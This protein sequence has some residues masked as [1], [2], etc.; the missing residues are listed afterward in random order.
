MCTPTKTVGIEQTTQVGMDGLATLRSNVMHYVYRVRL[1][2]GLQYQFIKPSLREWDHCS[3]DV[4]ISYP[5]RT[6]KI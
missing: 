4:S 5:H 3:A 2:Y 6:R 1:P